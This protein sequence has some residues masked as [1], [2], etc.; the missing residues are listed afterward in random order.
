MG[1]G[2]CTTAVFAAAQHGRPARSVG[3]PPLPIWFRRKWAHGAQGG[4]RLGAR[5]QDCRRVCRADGGFG[6]CFAARVRGIVHGDALADS[7]QGSRGVRARLLAARWKNSFRWPCRRL[8]CALGAD[9]G[10]G[11]NLR[12]RRAC[13]QWHTQGDTES[14]LGYRACLAGHRNLVGGT[15]R[16]RCRRQSAGCSRSPGAAVRVAQAPRRRARHTSQRQ[17]LPCRAQQ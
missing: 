12:V 15:R 14:L 3:H 5:G 1:H 8:R 16:A 4:R 13:G 10:R 6:R 2:R 11:G 7:C 17:W 9:A